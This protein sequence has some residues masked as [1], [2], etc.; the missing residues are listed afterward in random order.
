MTKPNEFRE[1][2]LTIQNIPYLRESPQNL[3]R[4][5]V[6]AKGQLVWVQTMFDM[7][8]RPI[9]ISAFVD[10]IGIISLDPQWLAVAKFTDGEVADN[11]GV[12][13]LMDRVA[14]L[15]ELVCHLLRRNEELRMT[16]HESSARGS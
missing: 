12:T 15:E 16:L 4:G 3:A 10:D 14:S 13:V 5:G 2:Y 9:S 7:E 11:P 8:E 1:V 6:L